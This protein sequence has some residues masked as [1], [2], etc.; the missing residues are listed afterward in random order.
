MESKSK[1]ETSKVAASH[2]DCLMDPFTSIISRR[3][4]LLVQASFLSEEARGARPLD[5]SCTGL[6]LANLAPTAAL[7]HAT[8]LEIPTNRQPF[9]IPI[10]LTPS[11]IE[12]GEQL[13]VFSKP[14]LVQALETHPSQSRDFLHEVLQYD[15]LPTLRIAV[16]TY[17]GEDILKAGLGKL[18][19]VARQDHIDYFPILRES[20]GP[21]A[22][23]F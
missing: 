18:Y 17:E 6:R 12:P 23:V 7:L 20:K 21:P 1:P 10:P 14:L 15:A 9:E 11:V 3:N 2:I 5:T 22:Q 16:S 4:G 13:E 8:W 19:N